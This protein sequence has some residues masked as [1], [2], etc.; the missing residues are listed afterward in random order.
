MQ[1]H[2]LLALVRP[3][4]EEGVAGRLHV[5][6]R[7]AVRIGHGDPCEGH[8]AAAGELLNVCPVLRRASKLIGDVLQ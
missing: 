1:V 8:L 7:R 6:L 2:G 4:V 5:G 3:R